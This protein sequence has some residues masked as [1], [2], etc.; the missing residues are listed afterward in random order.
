MSKVITVD[1]KEHT[2][3]FELP[4]FPCLFSELE[5]YCRKVVT[6][7]SSEL[8]MCSIEHI[9]TAIQNICTTLTM[10]LLSQQAIV[11]SDTDTEK[12]N[13]LRFVSIQHS[14]DTVAGRY[15]INIRLIT[16]PVLMTVSTVSYNKAQHYENTIKSILNQYNDLK[17][18]TFLAARVCSIIRARLEH[19]AQPLGYC[20][21]ARNNSIEM[22]KLDAFYVTHR[23]SGDLL[24]VKDYKFLDQATGVTTDY[25]VVVACL[26]S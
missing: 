13:P 14:M 20:I 10:E 3:D 22:S 16:K 4:I 21:A 7:L 9:Q 2:Y 8:A 26:F 24:D 19:D 5:N 12:I 23:D 25:V 18:A 1:E 11:F 15:I 6:T 17:L